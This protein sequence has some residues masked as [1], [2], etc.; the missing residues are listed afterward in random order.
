MREGEA[1]GTEVREREREREKRK[2]K[3]TQSRI[4]TKQSHMTEMKEGENS[5]APGPAHYIPLKTGAH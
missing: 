2:N 4:V 1:E 5:L 3:Q